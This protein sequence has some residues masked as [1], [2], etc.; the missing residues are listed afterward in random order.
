VE[1]DSPHPDNANMTAGVRWAESTGLLAWKVYAEYSFGDHGQCQDSPLTEPEKIIWQPEREVIPVDIDV[2]NNA[3]LNSAGS[4]LSPP[5]TRPYPVLAV[6]VRKWLPFFNVA[7]SFQYQDSVNEDVLVVAGLGY[8]GAGQAYCDY[9]RPVEEYTELAPFV[10]VEY[11]FRFRN[12][13]NPW[14][15]KVIDQGPIGW[16]SDPA[17]GLTLPGPIV[18]GTG[19]PVGNVA[20]DGTG[21]PILA[22]TAS[23]GVPSGTPGFYILGSD[24]STLYTPQSNPSVPTGFSIDSSLSSAFGKT[25]VWTTLPSNDFSALGV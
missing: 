20:L 15:T 18:D 24:R 19:T 17:S 5:V 11:R 23:S 14:Q 3:I 21:K 22:G 6:V 25:L 1:F 7:T 13:N 2:N 8:V 4:P 9:I 16:Y 10:Y 12:G